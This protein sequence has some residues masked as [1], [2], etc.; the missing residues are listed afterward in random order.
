MSD[1]PL[2]FGKVASDI[3]CY[4]EIKKEIKCLAQEKT[5]RRQ[6]L[7]SSP[8]LWIRHHN[9]P[10]NFIDCCFRLLLLLNSMKTAN[11]PR[12]LLC[13]GSVHSQQGDIA[14][15]MFSSIWAAFWPETDRW[16]EFERVNIDP[17]PR[18]YSK[19]NAVLHYNAWMLVLRLRKLG[20]NFILF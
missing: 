13:K 9:H 8:D 18:W 16:I 7:G 10:F 4:L 14:F 3:F 20:A 19:L 17:A 11:A 6:R 5:T 2:V 1:C 15:Y 12:T